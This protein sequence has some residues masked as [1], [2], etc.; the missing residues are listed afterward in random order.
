MVEAADNE[1][2]LKAPFPWFG[3]KARVADE[4]WAALGDV[5]HYVEPFAGSL[6]VLLGRPTWHKGAT[7]TVN[8]LDRYL[9]CVWRAIRE[10]PEET[11]KWCDAPVDECELMARHL[12]LLNTG[13]ERIA[14]MEADPDYFDARVAGY[15][16]YGINAW[17]GSGWCSGKGPWRIV[18]GR[19]VKVERAAGDAGRGVNRQLP[20]LGTA[21]QGV[22]RQRPHL[23]TAGQ[24][25]NRQ[26]PHLGDA[27]RGMNRQRPALG[28]EGYQT[29]KWN[30]DNL[31]DYF[32][33]LAR[34]LRR[35]RV[36]CGD[37]R[38][39]LTDGALACGDT[40][41]ILLDPPYDLDIRDKG[42]YNQDSPGIAADVRQWAIE[43]GEDK[44]LRIVLAGY[45]SEHVADMPSGWRMH[46]YSANKSYGRTS[47]IGSGR[48]N[49]A[50]RHNE[51]LWFSPGCLKEPMLWEEA[52]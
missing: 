50:N 37:W 48:G 11:A 21:G 52:K 2:P 12:W 9:C 13:A 44:R 24:G 20:H 42:C 22:N 8:D 47:T 31:V 14:L 41:G 34:R 46:A 17:I 49:D 38:R 16:L 5:D 19:V 40:V 29:E 6:A 43:H 10:Q 30:P 32:H 45:E 15:W 28:A 18:D 3:G 26:L 36:C 25:V 7:E 23:G 27:G 35:V 39:V 33:A 51:R 4:V 1:A